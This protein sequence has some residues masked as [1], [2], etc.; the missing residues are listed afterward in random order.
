MNLLFSEALVRLWRTVGLGLFILVLSACAGGQQLPVHSFVFDAINDS[1]DAEVIDYRYGNSK[2]P[3][4]SAPEWQK[5]ANKVRQG[6]GI[7]GAMLRGDTLYV[8][9]KIKASGEIHE[10]TANL[11]ACLP[12]DISE[13]IIYFKING[14]RLDVYLISPQKRAESDPPGPLRM[15]SDLKVMTLHPTCSR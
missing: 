1:P 8:K 14:S 15:Y 9:W 7:N 4:A 5:A 11:K 10:D 3:S 13:H 2:Q 6:V 12:Q